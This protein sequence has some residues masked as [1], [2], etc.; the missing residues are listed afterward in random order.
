MLKSKSFLLLLCICILFYAC[1][2][3]YELGV[4]Q[5]Q[6]I[7]TIDA[8]ITDLA[9]EQTVKISESFSSSNVV[10][11]LPVTKAKVEIVIN[12][13][14]RVPLTETTG[15]VYILPISFHTR[16]GE[17]YKLVF[18]KEDGTQYESTEE[19]QSVVSD[20]TRVYDE[21][22]IDG[23]ETSLGNRPANYVYLD[24]NDPA[25]EKNNYMWTW[26][27]WERQGV[28]ISCVGGRYFTTPVPARCRMEA[29]Y[30][31]VTYDYGCSETCW[32]IFYNTDLNV[33]SDVFSNG[34]S[35]LGRLIGKIP[36]YSASGALLEIKQQSIS[37][38]A[39]QYMKLLANQVQ[40]NGSLVDTPPAAI[41]GNVK[42][43]NKPDEPVAGFFMVTSVRTNKYWLGREN[44]SGL[45][46]P[47]GLLDHAINFEPSAGDPRRP[48]LAPCEESR[49]R[50]RFKP[51]GWV[52]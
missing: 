24:T 5:E 46:T 50:T 14:E 17:K 16:V 4:Q 52:N 9:D 49:V 47:L 45:A 30:S 8:T 27:L 39:Y 28:C 19:R 13:T 35:I 43:V 41:I 15:G 36:Y 40:N 11:A 33:Y 31:E 7:L 37:P 6:K 32:Q 10:Y 2:E 12:N 44:A 22:R 48:P 34:Q 3:P 23:I 18:K 26:K 20:I 42:N 38:S 25:S 1:V 21:F 29:A 51:D